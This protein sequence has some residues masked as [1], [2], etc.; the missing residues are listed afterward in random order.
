MQKEM[1]DIY[2]N[3]EEALRKKFAESENPE[4]REFYENF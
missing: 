4:D 1:S 2:I 3:Y